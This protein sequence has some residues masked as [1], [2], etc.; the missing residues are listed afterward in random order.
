MGDMEVRSL[1]IPM[2]PLIIQQDNSLQQVR[3]EQLQ[4]R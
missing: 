1:S 3:R 2:D 4:D